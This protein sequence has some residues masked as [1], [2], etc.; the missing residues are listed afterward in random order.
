MSREQRIYEEAAALWREIFHE[1]PPAR[2]DGTTMLEIITRSLGDPSYERLRSPFLR[3]ST[4]VG[5][6][7]PTEQG[8][9]LR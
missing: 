2:A 1:P 4:I 6:G 7:Q 8:S 3:P 9:G 5:P